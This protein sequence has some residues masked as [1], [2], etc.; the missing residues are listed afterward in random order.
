MDLVVGALL[1]GLGAAALPFQATL[2]C[3]RVEEGPHSFLHVEGGRLV[4]V[5]DGR[6][7]PLGCTD[8]TGPGEIRCLALDPVGNTFVAAERGLY[9]AGPDS[10]ALDPVDFRD[11]APPGRPTSVHVDARRRVWIATDEG[12]GVVDPSFFWGRT[13]GAEDGVGGKGPYRITAV[14]G[15]AFVLESGGGLLR[16]LPDRGPAPTVGLVTVDGAPCAEGA[17]VH[18]AYGASPV[19][20]AAGAAN[21]GATFR[22]RIDRHH[23]W[24]C[25]SDER[26]DPTLSPGRHDLEVIA[27]DRDL[28]RSRPFHAVIDVGVPTRYEPRFLLRLA[29][30]AAVVVVLL[31]VVVSVR[32]AR[33]VRGPRPWIRGLVGGAIA[34]VLLGQIAAGIFP[35]AKAWPFVGFTMYTETSAEG[36]MTYDEGLIGI[37][38]AGARR[39]IDEISLGSA[40]DD[41]WQVLGSLLEGGEPVAGRWIERYNEFRPSH[42]IE[43]VQVVAERR[44]LTAEGPVQVAPLVFAAF[45][46]EGGHAAR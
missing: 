45:G 35:H 36:R 27:V 20:G 41:R 44:R 32:A 25:L 43:R 34:A 5:L 39:R 26:P 31:S 10:E 22:W 3:L 17:A 46:K 29:A 33:G 14:E 2:P 42:P 12:L 13:I 19:L 21:G 8:P 18:I 15:S 38:A 23:I 4:R 6:S 9:L 37:D 7:I 40:C 28:N 24:R 30:L 11:G 16:Y 1:A